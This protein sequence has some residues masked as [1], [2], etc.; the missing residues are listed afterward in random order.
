MRTQKIKQAKCLREAKQAL[1]DTL[2]G[3]RYFNSCKSREAAKNEYRKLAKQLHPDKGGNAQE[4]AQ[5]NAEYDIVNELFD[6][7]EAFHKVAEKY[8][9]LFPDPIEVEAL[10]ADKKAAARSERV[11]KI[12]RELS[13]KENR[14]ALARGFGTLAEVFTRAWLSGED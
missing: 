6:E 1:N 10:K 8:P 3:L 11:Q 9:H 12:K 2:L 14:E 13:K 5:L 7:Y 4:T